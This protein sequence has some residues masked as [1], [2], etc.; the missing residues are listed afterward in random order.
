MADSAVLVTASNIKTYIDAADLFQKIALE[1]WPCLLKLVGS[2]RLIH[3][4]S[5]SLTHTHVGI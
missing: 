4:L 2:L 3:S 1:K 5:L